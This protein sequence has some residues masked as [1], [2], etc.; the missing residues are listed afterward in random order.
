MSFEQST[1]FAQSR[2]TKHFDLIQRMWQTDA[3][4]DSMNGTWV[5]PEEADRLKRWMYPDTVSKNLFNSLLRLKNIRNPIVVD[6]GAGPNTNLGTWLTEEHGGRYIAI[7]IDD[8]SL[9]EHADKGRETHKL[10]VA[11]SPLPFEDNAID[12][13][14]A[15][16][17]LMHL[18]KEKR[19]HVIREMLRVSR[20]AVILLDWDWNSVGGTPL[21]ERFKAYALT[22]C[23]R[24]GVEP[25]IGSRIIEE[26]SKAAQEMGISVRSYKG[27]DLRKEGAYYAE[28]IDLMRTM[29]SIEG[30][31]PEAET[32][33][34][35]L[36]AENKKQSPAPFRSASIS[37]AVVSK[38]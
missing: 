18:S 25:F 34:K 24:R 21:V 15:R 36:I 28:L 23:E 27:D 6:V 11:A 17:L 8:R 1:S 14:H 5:T 12:V 4:P 38:N 32:I 19:R 2:H 30:N 29:I 31:S 22:F 3:A 10:D 13:A 33:L 7:D 20:E 9:K 35:E 16:F 37:V 26:V